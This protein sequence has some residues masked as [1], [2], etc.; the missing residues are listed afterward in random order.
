M[1]E[2]RFGGTMRDLDGEHVHYLWVVDCMDCF[3]FSNDK[4]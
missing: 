3:V 1:W 2:G 4:K